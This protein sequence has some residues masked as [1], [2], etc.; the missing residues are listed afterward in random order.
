V[1]T[2]KRF[3][4]I[5]WSGAKG[6]TQ[7]G[8]QVAEIEANAAGPR[9]IRP[10]NGRKWSRS[11]AMEYI[12]QLNDKPTLVG[13]DFAFS[14]PWNFG[15]AQFDAR[16]VTDVRA[17]WA[18]VDSICDGTPDLYAGP[19]W[20]APDSPF[21]PYI[22]HHHTKH[23][24]ELYYRL[25]RRKVEHLE[26]N[27]ISVYHMAGPQVGAGSFSGMRMLH[28]LT[29]SHREG[30]AIWPF[31]VVDGAK[32][33]VVEIYPSLFYRKA[34]AR[35]PTSNDL[36]GSNHAEIDKTLGYYDAE[37]TVNFD[38]CRSVDQSDA[39]IAAAALRKLANS[40]AFKIPA[41]Q[42]FDLREGWIFGFPLG[43]YSVPA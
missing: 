29:S 25:K 14:V 17:L 24:G 7:S 34:G 42:D 9:L 6:A 12:T 20:T 3:V 30:I 38:D 32:T 11:G 2:F 31:D 19:V 21:R 1:R 41:S 39:L 15:G 13:I 10:P 22:F 40:L 23:R 5:D 8:I 18:L 16:Q 28:R 35:R 4:G 37:R 36:I 27:A 33:A 43:G 26:G